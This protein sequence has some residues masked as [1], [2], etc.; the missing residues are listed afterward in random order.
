MKKLL[1]GSSWG[2]GGV[3]ALGFEWQ[4]LMVWPLVGASVPEDSPVLMCIQATLTGLS[5]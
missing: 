4:E 3:G 5:G 2:G 1:T